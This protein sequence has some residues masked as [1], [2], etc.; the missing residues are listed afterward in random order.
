MAEEAV[1]HESILEGLEG[2]LQAREERKKDEA[3]GF[4][5]VAGRG[6]FESPCEVPGFVREDI[7]EPAISRALRNGKQIKGCTDVHGCQAMRRER[8]D[9]RLIVS[10]ERFADSQTGGDPL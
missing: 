3:A 8:Y 1:C 6:F 10:A 5:G 7:P 9:F 2:P 4:S